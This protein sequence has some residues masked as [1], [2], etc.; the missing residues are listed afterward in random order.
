MPSTPSSLP[1]RDALLALATVAH[2]QLA[3]D[4]RG[5]LLRVHATAPVAECL[6]W[7]SLEGVHPVDALLGFVAPDDWRAI[8]VCITG[9]AHSPRGTEAVTL[10]LLVDRAGATASVL[11]RGAALELLPGRPDGGWPTPA[12]VPSACRP[13]R[14]RGRH[15]CCGR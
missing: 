3:D 2:E 6:G 14:R 11:Q 7:K 8:G 12:A 15:W 1:D 4:P 13:H 5:A 9:R 10:T